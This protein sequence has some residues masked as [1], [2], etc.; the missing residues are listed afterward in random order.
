MAMKFWFIT[1]I[2]FTYVYILHMHYI[3]LLQPFATTIQFMNFQ[4]SYK[5]YIKSIIGNFYCG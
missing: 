4:P 2:V 5:I 1:H 3:G